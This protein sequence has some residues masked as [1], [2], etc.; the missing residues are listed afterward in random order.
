MVP[1]PCRGESSPWIR[2]GAAGA[3]RRGSGHPRRRDEVHG[4]DRLRVVDPSVM[5]T[6]ISGNTHAP[7][8]MIA[9]KA[10]EW[11]R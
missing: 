10:V 9:E 8:I 11:I 1:G 2:L 7:T 6:V 3:G 4:V 5:P